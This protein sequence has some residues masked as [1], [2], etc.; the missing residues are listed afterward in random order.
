MAMN[1]IMDVLTNEDKSFEWQWWVYVFVCPAA[2][3]MV[4]LMGEL[5]EK[6]LGL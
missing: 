3:V 2:F 4:M 5:F 1:K 6:W